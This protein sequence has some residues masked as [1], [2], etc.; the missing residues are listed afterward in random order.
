MGGVSCDRLRLGRFECMEF[1][2]RL[3]LQ[4]G[5]CSSEPISGLSL[6]ALHPWRGGGIDARAGEH[7]TKT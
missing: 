5:V 7:T 4:E 1:F 2:G 3:V 6:P